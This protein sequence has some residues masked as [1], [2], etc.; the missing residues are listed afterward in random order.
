M[1]TFSF[2][3]TLFFD[4]QAKRRMER[5]DCNAAFL[6]GQEHG[7][8][9]YATPPKVGIF[10]VGPGSILIRVQGADGL[11]AI[12]IVWYIRARAVLLEAGMEERQTPKACFV[13]RD[14]TTGAHR[15]LCTLHV[16]EECFSNEGPNGKPR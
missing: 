3:V 7:R 5:F 4:C 6:T 10:G 15:G 16:D 14:N 8:D 1:P 13:L 2:A 12:P 11:R 9:T